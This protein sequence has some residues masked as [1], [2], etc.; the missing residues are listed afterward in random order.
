MV[1]LSLRMPHV[2]AFPKALG[3]GIVIST[4]QP[5]HEDLRTRMSALLETY[6]QMLSRFR[7][8]SLVA[9]IGRAK[10]G[11]NFDFPDWTEPLFGLYD[12][13]FAATSGAIDPCIGEDLIRLGYDAS[14]SFTVKPR[15][16]EHL[17]ALRGR[18]TWGDDVERRGT[19]LITRRPVDLDFGACGKGYLVD[20]LGAFLASASAEFVTDAGGDLLIHSAEPIAI[21]L[22]DPD[23]STRAIGVAHIIDGALCASA[24]SRRHWEVAVNERTQL[25]IHHLLNA[26]DG[27]PVQQ[28][29]ATWVYMPGSATDPS[30]RV[31]EP[32][33]RATHGAPRASDSSPQ[34]AIGP[35]AAHPTALADGLATA[36]FTTSPEELRRAFSF[37]CVT[38]NAG[39]HAAVSSDF[40]GRLF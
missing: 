33:A 14:L 25:S 2:T 27:L 36:L 8:D 26:I 15:S 4:P 17:G 21:A 39:R 35:F 40:P 9:E 20:L 10:H 12:A 34:D 24:P 5:V 29:E 18:P 23:D 11:G 32:E 22:E 38:L 37:A 3:T 7:D 31:R 30:A 6:E 19:T 16:A 1:S 28:T 13:L